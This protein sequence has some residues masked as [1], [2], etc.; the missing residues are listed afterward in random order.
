[1]NTLSM[2]TEAEARETSGG[3]DPVPG[4]TPTSSAAYDLAYL[5]GVIVG[6]VVGA[7]VSFASAKPYSVTDWKTGITAGT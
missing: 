4:V 5:A 2:L 7:F 6:G 1:M 3:G